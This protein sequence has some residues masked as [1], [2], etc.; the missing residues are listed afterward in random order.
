KK[1]K[2][3]PAGSVVV[4][5]FRFLHATRPDGSDRSPEAVSGLRPG[6]SIDTASSSH[7]RKCGP[8]IF[9]LLAWLQFDTRIEGVDDLTNESVAG[10]RKI[11]LPAEFEKPGRSGVVLLI[12]QNLLI[13]FSPAN[14]RSH[15]C[16]V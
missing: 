3:G 1:G 12:K 16:R 9:L 11:F 2:T 13:W 7:F 6:G 15:A 8:G 10:C 5:Q 4:F 14:F